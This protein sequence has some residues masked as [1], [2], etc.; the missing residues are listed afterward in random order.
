MKNQKK[1]GISI[2]NYLRWPLFLSLLLIIANLIMIRISPETSVYTTAVTLIY[3]FISCGLY[4]YTRKG[5]F[6]GLVS[7]AQ[8]FEEVERQLFDEMSV[9]FALC[10]RSGNVISSNQ[11]FSDTLKEG[12]AVSGKN[13]TVIFPDITKEI[14][15]ADDEDV[16]VHTSF[17]GKRYSVELVRTR[18]ASEED[19]ESNILYEAGKIVWAMYFIDETEL[20]E[21]KKLYS[22]N[23]PCEGLIYLDNYDEAMEG[24]DDVRRSLLT[25]LID[26]KVSSYIS[27]MNGVMKK[28]EKDKYFFIITSENLARM[29]EDKFSIL[30]DTKS[31][32]IGNE[33]AVTL[34]I[35]IGADEGADYKQN[36]E[37]A[38]VAM[39]LALGRGGDQ[40]VIK[41]SDNIRYFGGK[42]HAVE[43]NTRVKARVKA[44]AFRELLENK[45]NVII[46]GHKISDIDCLGAAVGFYRI[47]VSMGKR[48]HIVLN[49]VRGSMRPLYESF[50]KNEYYPKDM[51][52]MGD[53]ALSLIDDGTVVVV[54]DVN[55]PGYTEEP[56][57]LAACDTI[58]VVDHHRKSS[59]TIDNAT[60][61]Y[62]EPFASSASEMV[63]EILQYIGDNIRLTPQEADAMYSGIMIDTQNFTNQTGVRTF[64]AAAY[65]KRSGADI[66]RIRK[67][68]RDNF[69]DYKAKA[70]AVDTAEIYR[71][72]FAIS[73][74]DPEGTEAPTVV[75]A[76]AANSLLEINGIKASIVLTKYQEKIYVSARSID[77]VN[78]QVMMEKLG[79]GGH[80]SVA[81]AQ[82]KDMSLDEAKTKIKE[83]IDDMLK[84]G[85]V[86]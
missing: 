41:S 85:E 74:C 84:E 70:R 18:L 26:R 35:G 69:A 60:L 1:S 75:G 24:V 51:F 57:L 17:S 34:S 68:F 23:R 82:L 64:E 22:D 79:G 47:A 71:D 38:R 61:S 50:I 46:M 39:D 62:V 5:L 52:V 63:A 16:I 30:K 78:V 15:R 65:L 43:K 25:A 33:M 27:S 37:Y 49:E 53:K 3:T 36:S 31:I 28:L 48:A 54:V 12:K 80:K 83:I 56:R 21:Y 72:H 29:M 81:G 32:N 11:A 42:S 44:H 4:L 13:I 77:E 73:E 8:G 7:F 58:V 14:L 2:A 40:V 45:D 59:D 20:V 10:D 55:R 66:I 19:E 67:I 86:S 9:P 76:Q 6:C